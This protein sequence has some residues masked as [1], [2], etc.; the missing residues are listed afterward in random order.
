MNLIEKALR[1]LTLATAG[2]AGLVFPVMLFAIQGFGGLDF[3][4]MWTLLTL[5]LIH[6]VSIALIFLASFKKTRSGR[7]TQTATAVIALNAVLLLATGG[8]LQVGTLKGDPEIALV[9][10]VPSVLFL[11]NC[12]IGF[13]RNKNGKAHGHGTHH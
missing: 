8:L 3:E 13:W 5:Y 6:P 10:A 9:L 2:L 7:A 12:S 4:M 1:I 11:L